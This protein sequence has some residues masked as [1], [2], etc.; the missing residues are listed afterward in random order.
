MT[1]TPP[2]NHLPVTEPPVNSETAPYWEAAAEGRLALPRCE[3]CGYVI[4]Y[5][6]Q[7][8]PECSSTEIGWFDASGRGTVYSF[9]VTRKSWGEWGQAAPF[10]I[11]YVELAEGPRVLTNIVGVD[12]DDERLTIGMEVTA[13]WDR[14][15]EGQGILRF[16]P[17]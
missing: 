4:W 16:T 8:C 3:Q 6:R 10:V 9:T 17:L 12:P 13:V 2:D 5:P 14:T 7:F 15:P 11:A 1:T